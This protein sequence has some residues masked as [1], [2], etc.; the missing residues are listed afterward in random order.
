M[1][2]NFFEDHCKQIT[3]FIFD[4]KLAFENFNNMYKIRGNPKTLTANQVVRN[5]FQ[6]RQKMLIKYQLACI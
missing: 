5:I 1:H 3:H 6:Q 2:P 4:R